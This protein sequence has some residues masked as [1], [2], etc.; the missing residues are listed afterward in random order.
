MLFLFL[1]MDLVFLTT[2]ETLVNFGLLESSLHPD[3]IRLRWSS[4]S[5]TLCPLI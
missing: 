5:D 1:L 4:V 3:K 2:D